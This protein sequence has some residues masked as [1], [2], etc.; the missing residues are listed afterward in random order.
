MG[1]TTGAVD[2]RGGRAGG[3]TD[4]QP[5]KVPTRVCPYT[6]SDSVPR[7]GSVRRMSEAVQGLAGACDERVARHEDQCQRLM[8]AAQQE[9]VAVTLSSQQLYHVSTRITPSADA[10]TS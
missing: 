6:P 5:T 3:R 10:Q 8:A 9:L 4:R 2:G 7:V 1:P